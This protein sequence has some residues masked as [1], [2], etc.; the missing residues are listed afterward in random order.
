[1]T[2]NQH[3]TTPALNATIKR[4]KQNSDKTTPNTNPHQ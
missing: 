3:A 2:I 1:M 4:H